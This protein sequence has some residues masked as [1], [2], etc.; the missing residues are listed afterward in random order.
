MRSSVLDPKRT[1]EVQRPRRE[2]NYR[3]SY[4]QPLAYKT[5]R[6]PSSPPSHRTTPPPYFQR[7]LQKYTPAEGWAALALLAVAIYC[8]CF[9]ILEANWV[10]H[11]AFLLWS[12]AV[13]LLIGLVIAKVPRI[14]QPV[15]HLAACV[16]GIWLAIW[17]TSAF[18]YHVPWTLVVA[19]SRA[20]V[21]GGVAAGSIP[22]TEVLFFFYLAFLTY[23]LGY[24]GSWLIYRARLP[25]LVALVYC[26][27]LLVNLNYVKQELYATI[28]VVLL[29]G[30]LG[31]LIARIQ[32]VNQIYHWTREGL[33]TDRPWLEAITRR[34]M[35]GASILMVVTLIGSALLPVFA[36]DKSGKNFW[37]NLNNAWSNIVNGHVSLSDPKSLFKPYQTPTNFFGDQ[38]AISGSVN[39]PA[40]EVMTYTSSGGAR[41]LQGFT[42]NLYDGH[43][44]TTTLNVTNARSFAANS[45]LP[46][47]PQAKGGVEVTVDVTLK[48]PPEST[49]N[50]IFG[51]A[52]PKSFDKPAI[53]Y[54]DGTVGTWVQASPLMS[55]EHYRVTS[56]VPSTTLLQN[57]VNVPLPQHDGDGVWHNDNYY[58]SQLTQYYLKVPGDLSPNV[59]T[60]AKQWTEGATDT[61]TFLKLL[62]QHLGDQKKFSYSVNN[63]PIPKNVDVVDWLLQTKV[64]Y[65]TYYAS[66][67]AVMARLFGIPTRIV[68]GFTQGHYDKVRKVWAVEGPDAHSWVQAYFPGYGWVD[69]DPTPGYTP[70]APPPAPAPTQAPKP[71]QAP[72]KA[73]PT[74]PPVKKA[75]NVPTPVPTVPP[76]KHAMGNTSNTSVIDQVWLI[77]LSVIVLVLS[78]L[79]FVA[80]VCTYW[81]RNLYANS[82]L[83]AGM[84]WRL[85]W[86]ASRAG[87]GP[88]KW[89]T[90]Y[91]YS[92]MLS[93][94][95]GN[96]PSQLWQLTDLFVRDR[97]GTPYQVPRQVEEE[98]AA[99]HLWP[100][101]RN[102]F[103]QLLVRKKKV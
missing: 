45:E 27:I 66:A 71:T 76:V 63:A 53:I 7:F 98:I 68:N 75:Q 74:P 55:N 84:F 77:W 39:L 34:C 54:T 46:L 90:P 5:P 56:V 89:Q 61:Y 4:Q 88:R 91:E 51:P 20:A 48:R 87:L 69:F 41:Y 18:A 14:P 62:E 72:L 65:C 35:A 99:R 29:A 82:T 12:P 38:L 2:S 36:Q 1:P 60:Q 70:N 10:K 59:M 83:V 9:S 40:G 58:G 78:L 102:T 49:K 19:S 81:W 21:T 17:V 93:Q 73:T 26:S 80:A 67:M 33:H 97:W 92:A 23:F 13:G 94:H 101:L 52:Q 6:H 95:L 96:H 103:L 43:T 100:T 8:V 24:F 22:T 64:G 57:L 79:V 15:L 44:W 30:A 32:L 3:A 86:I 28:L 47:E 37:D 50:Y 85:C 25:W 42:Y 16:V 11:G 31:L